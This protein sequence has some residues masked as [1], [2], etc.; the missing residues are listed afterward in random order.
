MQGSYF[1]LNKVNHNIPNDLLI[2]IW[3]RC[4]PQTIGKCRCV[5]REWKEILEGEPFLLQQQEIYS[6]MQPSFLLHIWFSQWHGNND[7]FIRIASDSGKRLYLPPLYKLRNYTNIHIVGS[8]NGLLCLSYTDV[9][10]TFGLLVW[11]A[12]TG[13]IRTIPRPPKD[14]FPVL[15]P[16]LSFVHIPGT[17]NYCVVHTY[18]KRLHDE[19]LMYQMYSSEVHQWSRTRGC[20]GKIHR[21]GPQ[22]VSLDGV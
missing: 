18:R 21:L 1:R 5:S 22:S 13:A 15:L 4:D 19:F 8:Q 14:G 2:D 11:N 6:S 20:N 16:T 9:A 12:L 7:S 3:L 17:A 10:G